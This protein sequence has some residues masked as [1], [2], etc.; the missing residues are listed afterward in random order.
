MSSLPVPL[1]SPNSI[2]FE[3]CHAPE[4]ETIITM[5]TATVDAL[6]AMR[7]DINDIH[8]HDEIMMVLN[9]I[10]SC[11]N[12][13]KLLIRGLIVIICLMVEIKV[14]W[15]ICTYVKNGMAMMVEATKIVNNP[16]EKISDYVVQTRNEISERSNKFE[17]EQ[18]NAEASLLLVQPSRM[19]QIHLQLFFLTR[20][21]CIKNDVKSANE[22]FFLWRPFR[23]FLN[24]ISFVWKIF[25][26]LFGGEYE[27]WKLRV[28]FHSHLFFILMSIVLYI[29]LQE[30]IVVTK[31][32]IYNVRVIII[33]RFIWILLIVNLS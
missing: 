33:K 24:Q 31:Y 4:E 9:Y 18:M 2:C 23:W 29:H 7:G 13:M 22:G 15:I 19:S 1:F 20:S 28:I 27:T 32:W 10:S 5:N 17:C 30:M 21:L 6:K 12:E 25:R 11:S 14:I 16:K 26:I 3:C 8:I